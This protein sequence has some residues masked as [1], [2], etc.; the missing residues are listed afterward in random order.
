MALKEISTLLT[1]PTRIKTNWNKFYK[2]NIIVF[3]WENCFSH[4]YICQYL[5]YMCTSKQNHVCKDNIIAT[6]CLL[7]LFEINSLSTKPLYDLMSMMSYN[8]LWYM[9]WNTNNSKITLQYSTSKTCA[10]RM[11]VKQ[12]APSLSRLSRSPCHP[13]PCILRAHVMPA[14][15]PVTDMHTS[16]SLT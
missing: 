14:C 6:N 1:D 16:G 15:F 7:F 11:G 2:V 5:V 9:R 12:K 3:W 4:T 13:V 8:S 10:K